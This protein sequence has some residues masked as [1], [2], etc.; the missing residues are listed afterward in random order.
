[1][2]VHADEGSA[3]AAHQVGTDN[4]LWTP[5]RQLMASMV[6]LLTIQTWQSTADGHKNR[7]RPKPIPRPG[8]VEKASR[9]IGGK[10]TATTAANVAALL[11]M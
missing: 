5:D 3:V 6:D 10:K 8:I 11:G 7:N 2:I 9:R 1:M 4:A